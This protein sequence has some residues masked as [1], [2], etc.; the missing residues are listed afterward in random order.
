M[1]YS[2][3]GPGEAIQ[4]PGRNVNKGLSKTLDYDLISVNAL[5]D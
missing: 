3:A 1:G 5:S 4:I 2:K